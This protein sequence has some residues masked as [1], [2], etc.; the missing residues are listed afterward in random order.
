M[1]TEKVYGKNI[2]I[3]LI[4]HMIFF[5]HL[6]DLRHRCRPCDGCCLLVDERDVV[7]EPDPLGD[8]DCVGGAC[9]GRFPDLGAQEAAVLAQL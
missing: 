5:F 3:P 4:S 7:V 2:K 6:V 1:K 9:A 8:R